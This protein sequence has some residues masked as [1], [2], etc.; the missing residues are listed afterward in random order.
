MKFERYDKYL[1]TDTSLPPRALLTAWEALADFHN[2]LVLVGGLAV[3]C[4]TKPPLAGQPGP[5]TLD[6][7]FAISLAVDSG[8]GPTIKQALREQEFRWIADDKRFTREFPGLR[9]HVDLLTD[10]GKSDNGTRMV[11]DGLPVGVMPGIDRALACGRLVPVSGLNLDGQSRTI[12]IKVAEVGPML[13]LKLNAF[14]G[15]AG[16]RAGKDAHDILDLAT[17]YLDGL[18]AAVA[19]FNAEKAAGNRAMRHA[20]ACLRRDFADVDALGPVAC[21]TFRISGW[22]ES[23]ANEEAA[24]ALRQECVTLAQ[25]LLA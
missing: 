3:R 18:E 13:A 24:L 16:R 21:A 25:A 20:L 6:V 1:T 15:P 23:S 5:V 12:K 19:G 17:R 11:D 14:G 4:L 22:P 9:L 7:D 10:D 2:D 8:M